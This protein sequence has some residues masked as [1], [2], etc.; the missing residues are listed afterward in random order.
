MRE[1]V[2]EVKRSKHKE[3]ANVKAPSVL[4]R[5]NPKRKRRVNWR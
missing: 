3:K 4:Y 2:I 1:R 5:R